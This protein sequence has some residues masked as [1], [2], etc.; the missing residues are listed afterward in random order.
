MMKYELWM[1]NYEGWRMND[2]G[3]WFQAVEGFCRLTDKLT[4][5]QTNRLCDCRVAFL[6]EKWEMLDVLEIWDLWYV[7]DVRNVRYVGDLILDCTT[8]NLNFE[9]WLQMEGKIGQIRI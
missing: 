1:K 8:H 5:G 9:K 6:T 4:D 2:D 7:G 3:C